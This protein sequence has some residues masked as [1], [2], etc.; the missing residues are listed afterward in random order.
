EAAGSKQ[1][2]EDPS[3]SI[4]EKSEELEAL[5][6]LIRGRHLAPLNWLLHE[7]PDGQP[8]VGPGSPKVY[9]R[10]LWNQGQIMQVNEKGEAMGKLVNEVEGRIV[11]AEIYDTEFSG[12]SGFLK[13]ATSSLW[14]RKQ[15]C[16][17]GLI[18]RNSYRANFKMKFLT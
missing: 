16:V 5:N 18:D 3:S 13:L 1:V 4:L 10:K 14:R 12:N 17:D 8:I 6:G 11:H 9:F 15:Y 2:L 7:S